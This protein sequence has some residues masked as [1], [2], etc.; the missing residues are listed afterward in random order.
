[1]LVG[2]LVLVTTVSILSF[3]RRPVCPDDFTNEK[4]QM[5][6]IDN[7]TNDFYDKHPGASLTEWGEA[8]HQF[9]IDNRCTKALQRY[10]EA[11][12]MQKN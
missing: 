10:E 3:A 4:D 8:R 7:W 2:V 12:A 9:W 11:K 5:A 6:S 1:M